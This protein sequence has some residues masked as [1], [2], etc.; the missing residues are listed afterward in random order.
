LNV[1]R[2]RFGV[3]AADEPRDTEV[4]RTAAMVVVPIAQLELL[5]LD[6][7]AAGIGDIIEAQIRATM[8]FVGKPSKT[9][10]PWR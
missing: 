8:F 6:A 4:K 10:K 5:P 3:S 2:Y 1:Q 7:T 9:D